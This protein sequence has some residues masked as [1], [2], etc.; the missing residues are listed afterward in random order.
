MIFGKPEP[1]ARTRSR[2][3]RQN[4][5]H[6]HTVRAAVFE[7]AK[8]LCEACWGA[9]PTEMHELVP[10]SQCG[11]ISPQNSVAI[12][13]DCHVLAH[14]NTRRFRESFFPKGAEHGGK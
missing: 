13:H 1:L 14:K 10:R 3:K 11:K 8:G 9:P 7:R 6:V 12:C 4:Q 2:K 5:K